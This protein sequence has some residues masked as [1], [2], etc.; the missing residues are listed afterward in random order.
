[1]NWQKSLVW[2]AA[3]A[4]ATPVSSWATPE[5]SIAIAPAE[6]QAKRVITG[7]VVD[8]KDGEPLPG[9]TVSVV[10]DKNALT[11]TDID[12]NFSLSIPGNKSVLLSRV[13]NSVCLRA[14]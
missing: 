13:M 8:A 5:P 2:V 4:M 9:A 10:G 1:M 12:G 7:V 14:T 6:Q 3:F 11:A